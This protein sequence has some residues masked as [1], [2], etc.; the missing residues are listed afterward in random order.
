MDSGTYSVVGNNRTNYCDYAVA[1][2][3]LTSGLVN[4]QYI[5]N[6]PEFDSIP[7]IPDGE[8]DIKV[9]MGFSMYLAW[10]NI[11]YTAEQTISINI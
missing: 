5:S 3:Q 4:T 2:I 6:K 8:E 9:K 1:V 11:Q 10:I 7:N